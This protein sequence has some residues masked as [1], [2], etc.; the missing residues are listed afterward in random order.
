MISPNLQKLCIDFQN[1]DGN[2]DE[3]FRDE[4]QACPSM[5]PLVWYG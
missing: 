4:N 5:L 2:L 1:R 3:F